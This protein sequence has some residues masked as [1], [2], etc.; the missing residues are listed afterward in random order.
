MTAMI[1][2][3]EATC[4]GK[5]TKQI[6]TWADRTSSQQD[7]CWSWLVCFAGVVSNVVICGFTYSYGILFP[8]LLDEFQQGKAKTG[9]FVSRLFLNERRNERMKKRWMAVWAYAQIYELT[10]E[11][12]N[13]ERANVSTNAG[14][15]E[16]TNFYVHEEMNELMKE[17]VNKCK[18]ERINILTNEACTNK[19]NER[20]NARTNKLGKA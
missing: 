5:K 11:R 10:S 18:S 9:I 6:V 15:K 14:T 12:E 7:S 2:Q 13:D 17:H 3:V 20:T 4:S 19:K 1:K 8:T 16:W